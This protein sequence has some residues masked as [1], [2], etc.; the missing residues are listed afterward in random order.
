M[1]DE[2]ILKYFP[3]GSNDFDECFWS[4]KPLTISSDSKNYAFP[5]TELFKCKNKKLNWQIKKNL[6]EFERDQNWSNELFRD[7]LNG[8][9]TPS[10]ETH[11]SRFPSKSFLRPLASFFSTLLSR[12]NNNLDGLSYKGSKLCLKPTVV[13]QMNLV[14]LTFG[15]LGELPRP[16]FTEKSY[17][18]TLTR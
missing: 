16:T 15:L 5:R 2:L 13:R 7:P 10:Q 4:L 6:S 18:A 1:D 12:L 17:A 8:L 14:K 9:S 11:D 3:T